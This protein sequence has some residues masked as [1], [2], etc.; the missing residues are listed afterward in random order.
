MI[1]PRTPAGFRAA[2]EA[3]GLTQRQL[4]EALELGKDGGRTVRR[5]EAEDREIPGPAAVAVRLMLEHA[6]RPAKVLD[7][8]EGREIEV[9]APGAEM[10]IRREL[11][12]LRSYA[13]RNGDRWVF[14]NSTTAPATI[15]EMMKVNAVW[16]L[17]VP[18][19]GAG[20]ES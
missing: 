9:F 8:F 14:M 17:V 10:T 7:E 16:R 12:D 19:N 13:Y 2:R 20:E 3:L 6:W 4:A 11:I 1:D 18:P 5:W 15:K